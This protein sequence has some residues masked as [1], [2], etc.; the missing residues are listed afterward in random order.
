MSNVILNK[1][2]FLH[3]LTMLFQLQNTVTKHEHTA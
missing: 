1:S 3:Y 2:F